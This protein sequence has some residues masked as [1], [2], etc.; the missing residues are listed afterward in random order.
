MNYKLTFDPGAVKSLEKLDKPI[1]NRILSKCEDLQAKPTHY[2]DPLKGIDLWRLRV[3]DYRVL[4]DL[5][6]GNQ[7]I[8]VVKIG[9]RDNFYRDLNS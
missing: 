7:E 4:F 6:Q 2:A 8:H 9:H 1:R 3:G 5:Y